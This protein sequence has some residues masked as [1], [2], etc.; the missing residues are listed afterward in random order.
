MPACIRAVVFRTAALALLLAVAVPTALQAQRRP[1]DEGAR[2]WHSHLEDLRRR[3]VF[4]PAAAD[5]L[6]NSGY[7][8][9][10]RMKGV[11]LDQVRA[12]T[13]KVRR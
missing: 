5:E 3:A 9:L 8:T 1:V 4:D 10:A 6:A 2:D 12:P 7:E 13:P 11:G